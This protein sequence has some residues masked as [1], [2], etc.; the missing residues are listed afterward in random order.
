MP[1]KKELFGRLDKIAPA[2]C[3]F[4]TNTSSLSITEMS[5]GLSRGV[6]GMHFFNPAPVMKLV[7]IIAGMMTPPELVDQPGQDAGHRE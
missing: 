3:V 1:L 5:L 2:D 4:A 6:I 7:E